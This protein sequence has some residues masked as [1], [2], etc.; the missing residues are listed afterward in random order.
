M[1]SAANL[2]HIALHDDW[3]TALHDTLQSDLLANIRQFL[4]QQKA[5]NKTIYPTSGHIFA[6]LNLTPLSQVKVVIVGQDPYHG[7]GQAHGLAFSVNQGIPL[8]PSLRN[9]YKELVQDLAAGQV[10][11]HGNL[12]H[13]A[14]QGVLL[15]NSVLTVE[16][17]Q[18]ASHQGQGWE[19]FTDAVL[20]AVSQSALPCV[21]VLW[22]N[23][24]Q[25]KGRVIDGSKHLVI[26][27]AHPSPLSANRGGF[28]GSK[29]FTAANH[30]LLQHGRTPINWL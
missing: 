21:F 22:G 27:S 16:A 17:H 18:P 19:R 4:Q 6:A 7:P 12:T 24:A 25:Q 2:Q 1:Q 14:E 23:Y 11:S 26:Q 29:P 15:L 28:F 10:P 30:F 3:K 13:W 8:P 20:A 9:I 5:A